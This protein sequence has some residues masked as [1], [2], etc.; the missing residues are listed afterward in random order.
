MNNEDKILFIDKI[1][2]DLIK[3]RD[4]YASEEGPREFL[5]NH[6]LGFL[7]S[8]KVIERGGEI[9]REEEEHAKIKMRLPGE[10]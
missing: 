7:V 6:C 8:L 9:S 1:I 10:K 3:L 2:E 5:V 4:I